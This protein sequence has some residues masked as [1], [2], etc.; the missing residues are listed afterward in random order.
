[1]KRTKLTQTKLLTAAEA[2]KLKGVSRAAIYAAIA[3]GR[4]PHER[5]LGRLALREADV[6]AWTPMPHAGRRKGT[7]MSQE[8][9][10][11]I[12]AGQK[13]RWQRRKQERT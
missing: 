12:S 1:M 13:R 7:P 6:L 10:A 9:K 11:R 3:P 5:I 8:A 2:A 4:L